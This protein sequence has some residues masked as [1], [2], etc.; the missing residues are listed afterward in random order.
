MLNRYA[1]W[2][3]MM[4]GLICRIQRPPTRELQELEELI[5]VRARIRHDRDHWTIG[6]EELEGLAL[7]IHM[8]VQT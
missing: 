1:D 2:G 8:S 3:Q 5:L 4:M 7:L 6:K